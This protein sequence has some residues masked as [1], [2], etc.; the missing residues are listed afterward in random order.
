M[1]FCEKLIL[2][3]KRKGIT[4][5]E[6]SRAVGVSRQSVYKWESGQ[7]YPEAAKLMEIRRLYGVSIDHLLDESVSLPFS[8]EVQSTNF[9]VRK[10]EYFTQ[11]PSV[12]SEPVLQEPSYEEPKPIREETAVQEKRETEQKPALPQTQ[13][14]P[15]AQRTPQQTSV[16]VMK[17]KKKQSSLLDIVG[18]FFG[19]KR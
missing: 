10:E 11:P 9:T 16:S 4:Q 3:R 7:S 2:L 15:Q 18:A 14:Q 1:K 12:S 5:E 8:Q 13:P 6:F 17:K 19:K